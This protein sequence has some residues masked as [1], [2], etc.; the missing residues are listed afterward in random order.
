VLERW[1]Q[2]RERGTTLAT[3][4]RAGLVTFLTMAYILFVN[5]QILAQAGLPKD[6]VAIA[7]AVA[8]AMATLVMGIW[9]DYPFALAPGM[10]LNAYF[11]FGV[12]GN[13]GVDWKVALAAVFAEGLLFLAL[14]VA[15]V[16]RAILDAIPLCLKVATMSGI[17][18]F[19]AFIGFRNAGLVVAHPATLVTLGE[20]T[21]PPTL[22]ALAGLLVTAALLVVEARGALLLG[23]LA[24]AGVGWLLGVAPSPHAVFSLPRLPSQTFLAMDF[25]GLAEAGMVTVVLAFLFVDFFDTAGT[26]IGVGRLAGFID[27][28]GELPRADRAFA[29]DALGTVAGAALGTSTV[30]SYIESATGVEE[31]GR[32]GLT[33]VVVGLLFLLALFF[34]PL[35]AAVPPA[36]TA[37][38]L[39]VVGALMMRGARDL[40]WRRAEESVPSFLTLAAMPFTFSIANGIS[41]G[42]VSWVGIRLATGRWRDVPPLMGLLALLLVA[43]YGS[44]AVG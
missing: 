20:V 35:L 11:T 24:T 5:P 16:R 42:I 1:F 43:Y 22:L 21:A 38:A 44:R 2:L 12:V 30:T 10:G 33:A 3:E 28:R 23:I 27:D 25:S 40:D 32:T 26:L 15:G 17:G 8:S 31:G 29:A 14:T 4:V 9:A 18:L 19:L 39:V 13:L 36:A 34:V 37:P 7:T 41:L 6:D